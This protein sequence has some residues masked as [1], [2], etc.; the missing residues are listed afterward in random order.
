[1]H[2]LPCAEFASAR[3]ERDCHSRDADGM[4]FGAVAVLG[5]NGSSVRGKGAWRPQVHDLAAKGH[6][7]SE[8]RLILARRSRGHSNSCAIP[9]STIASDQVAA[10]SR[11]ESARA[12]KRLRPFRSRL[13]PQLPA[14]AY[15]PATAFIFLGR[16]RPPIGGSNGAVQINPERAPGSSTRRVLPF[17]GSEGAAQ[18]I[19]LPVL[20]AGRPG[21]SSDVAWMRE[22][23]FRLSV[24]ALVKRRATSM[25]HLRAF[26]PWQ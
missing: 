10:S 13:A 12:I 23:P 22:R 25:L 15:F 17:Q 24:P 19:L 7:L 26:Y 14:R 16:Q 4:P 20:S 21:N 5:E 9:K 18:L 8:R 1:M 6:A 3:A 11:S 2:I